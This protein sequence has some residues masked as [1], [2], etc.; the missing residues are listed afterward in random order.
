MFNTKLIKSIYLLYHPPAQSPFAVNFFH[1][2]W[3]PGG[4]GVLKIRQFSWTPYVYLP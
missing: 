4:G 1:L 2:N 3:V